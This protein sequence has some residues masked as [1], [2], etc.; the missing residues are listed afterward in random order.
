MKLLHLIAL[1]ALATLPAC[2]DESQPAEQPQPPM[3]GGAMPSPEESMV[4]EGADDETNPD[5]TIVEAEPDIAGSEPMDNAEPMIDAAPM[6]DD[7]GDEGE[8]Q[9]T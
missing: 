7:F 2:G 9:G 3:E 5:E 1:G 6:T 4:D 8:N